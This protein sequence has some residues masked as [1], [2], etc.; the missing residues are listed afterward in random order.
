MEM[1]LQLNINIPATKQSNQMFDSLTGLFDSSLLQ[2]HSQWPIR[3]AGQ[4]NKS[5]RMLFQFFFANC[6]L[7]FFSAQLHPGN[8]AAKILITGARG[9]QKRKAEVTTKAQ[10]HGEI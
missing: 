4:A 6:A 3:T 9:N 8:Q 1:P 5:F 10:R 2:S 7:A